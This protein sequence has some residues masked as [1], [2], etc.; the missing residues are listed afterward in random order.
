MGAAGRD[1]HNFNVCVKDDAAAKRMGLKH[2]LDGL[3]VEID[4]QVHERE[5][6]VAEGPLGLRV[7]AITD[8][9]AGRSSARSS[10][11]APFVTSG[12]VFC[13]RRSAPTRGKA[14]RHALIS[15]GPTL[16]RR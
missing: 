3:Q 16:P 6:F 2:G 7:L 13:E 5:K 1:F 10:P 4:R 14:V 8:G 12:R 11:A 15:G 9:H